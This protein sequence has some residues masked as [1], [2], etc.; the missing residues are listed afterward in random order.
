MN[1][2]DIAIVFD[3]GA[4]NIR[5]IAIDTQGKISA[6]QSFA[7]Q[8]DEDPHFK[9]GKIWDIEKLWEK[10][11]Q[12]AKVVT[13]QINT[14]RIAGVTVTTFGVDGAFTDSNNRLLYPVIS[15]QCSRTEP[16]AKSV[17]KYL[18][19]KDLYGISG[20]FPY[21]F[22]TIF[23][24]IWFKENRPDIIAKASKFLFI[25][26]LFIQ[27]LGGQGINDATMMGTSMM[28]NL[29]AR[30]FSDKIL[31]SLK[32]PLSLFGTPAEPGQS[33]GMVNEAAYRETGLPAGTPLFFA[34]HDTQFALFG[35]GA[36]LRQPVLSSGT[37]EILMARSLDF[38]A[39]E[40]GLAKN[41]TTE[42]DAETG[43]Y[44]IGQ[45]WLGSGV[46]EWF[47][48]NFYPG[49]TGNEL[50]ETMISEAERL[51]PGGHGLNINSAFFRDGTNTGGTIHGLSI[52]TT[53]AEIYLALLESLAY[54]LRESLETLEQAGN[55]KA[56]KIICVGGGSKSRL[57]NQLRADVCNL[58]IQLIDHKETTVLGAALFTFTGSGIYKSVKE[59][60]EAIDFNP[61]LIL[62]SD[63]TGIYNE[64]YEKN[65]TF[66]TK[67]Y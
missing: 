45:N 25:P 54:R 21:S 39:S 35:S 1:K 16:I 44:N 47:S 63:N 42:A 20:V 11:C 8:T 62:P 10:F 9:G 29:R 38:A 7:N 61:K 37:W 60:R 46:L 50:Y 12:A 4:T 52:H 36:E 41:L 14:D 53:R 57:W 17:D 64:L 66:K 18:P 43:L 49:L 23:K 51:K 58:P 33:A 22:N 27:K 24:M 28:A 3:C 65:L 13:E 48:K 6:S 67:I 31:N 26:S 15:W 30:G 32:L 19:L 59:A 34:G 55:F 5:V 2:K 56:E 40:A